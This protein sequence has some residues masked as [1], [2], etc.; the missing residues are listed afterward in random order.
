M[1][2][3]LETRSL[4]R[5]FGA[6]KAVDNVSFSLVKGELLAMIGPNGAG[7]TTILD[8][9]HP[10]GTGK[11]ST[12]SQPPKATQEGRSGARAA[13]RHVVDPA[14]VEIAVDTQSK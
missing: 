8:A 14:G 12:T 9:D 7:K 10:H 2:P 13:G 3:V 11:S 5:S 4:S 1:T 6:I